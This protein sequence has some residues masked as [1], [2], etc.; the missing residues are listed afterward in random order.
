MTRIGRVGNA[1]CAKAV[2]LAASNASP[3]TKQLNALFMKPLPRR[4]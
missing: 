4:A 3:A 2:V 1:A